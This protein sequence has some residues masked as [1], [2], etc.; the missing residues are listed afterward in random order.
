MQYTNTPTEL[1][2]TTTAHGL[3]LEKILGVE[4]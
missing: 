3:L 2:G 1:M 4:H